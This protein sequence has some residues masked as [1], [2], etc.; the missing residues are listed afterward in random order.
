MVL[1][2]TDLLTVAAKFLISFY[3]VPI[4]ML[5]FAVLV[6]GVAFGWKLVGLTVLGYLIVGVL[7][8]PVLANTLIRAIG[9]VYIAGPESHYLVGFLCNA[10]TVGY[11]AERKFDRSVLT[12]PISM[13]IGTALIYLR[14]YVW[15]S[16]L[17]G[18]EKAFEFGFLAFIWGLL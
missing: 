16:S 13:I 5:V 18:L 8:L 7:E 2:G 4:T 17:I 11:L 15:L 6:I 12:T 10:V 3:P 14:G 1:N 9:L